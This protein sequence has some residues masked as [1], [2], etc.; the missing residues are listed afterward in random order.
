MNDVFCLPAPWGVTNK[1]EQTQEPIAEREN[2]NPAPNDRLHKLDG[3]QPELRDQESD[4]AQGQASV[5]GRADAPRFAIY[6]GTPEYTTRSAPKALVHVDAQPRRGISLA[7]SDKGFPSLA[8]RRRFLAKAPGPVSLHFRYLTLQAAVIIVDDTGD[9]VAGGGAPCRH[10][11]L[12]I[13]M[14]PLVRPSPLCAA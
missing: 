13:A 3:G 2:R 8:S 1:I 10:N 11:S 12:S 14:A 4:V 6:V 7:H 5:S 9:E